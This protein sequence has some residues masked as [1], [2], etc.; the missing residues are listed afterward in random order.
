MGMKSNNKPES[1][2]QNY[3]RFARSIFGEDLLENFLVSGVASLLLIRLFLSLT[4]YPQ[5]GGTNFHFAHMLWGGLLMMAAIFIALGF[6]SRPA[7]ELAAVLG[8]IGFGAFIDELGKF[9][10]RDNNYFF[11]PTIALIYVTFI[12]IYLAIRAIFNNRPMTRHEN[13]ANAFEIMKQGSINGLSA[14]DEQIIMNILNQSDQTNPLSEYLRE[15]MLHIRVVPSRR[16]YILNRW[17]Q[18]LDSFYQKLVRKWWFTGVL[19]AFF[20]FTAVTGFSAAIGVIIYPWN[21][22][23]GITA[24]V[25]ILLS[26]LQMWKSRFPNLQVPLSVGVVGASFLTTWVIWINPGGADLPFAEWAQFIC[27]SATAALIMTGIV[28]MARSRLIA[29]QMFQRAILISILLTA[30][31]AFYQYQFFALIGVFLNILILVALRYMINRE[32]V[33][34][35]KPEAYPEMSPDKSA[36]QDNIR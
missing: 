29:Y 14:E 17:K 2:I 22:A 3:F 1:P 36:I 28:Y 11:Q 33:R 30:V 16:P 34:G 21:M 26:L 24:V 25:I 12:L 20:A 35:R 6:L 27:S 15:M 9:I 8:G 10:T 13:L 32:K 31:F 7:H 4:G 18:S 5:I 19:I 23:L